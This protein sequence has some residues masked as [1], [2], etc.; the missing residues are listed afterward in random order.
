[1]M[2]NFYQYYSQFTTEYE[3]KKAA[4]AAP[5]QKELLDFITLTRWDNRANYY[6]VAETITKSHRK[7][8]TISRKYQSILEKLVATE[9]IQ[10]E[11]PTYSTELKEKDKRYI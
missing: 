3:K 1:M 2:F 4:F 8:V 7:L 9:V 6:R 10:T 5:V 11:D